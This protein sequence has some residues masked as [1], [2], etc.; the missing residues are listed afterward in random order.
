MMSTVETVNDVGKDSTVYEKQCKEIV[1]RLFILYQYVKSVPNFFGRKFEKITDILYEW[2]DNMGFRLPHILIA[3]RTQESLEQFVQFIN[4]VRAL[5]NSQ[6]YLDAKDKYQNTPL[7][8]AMKAT[9]FR[10]GVILLDV[11]AN[12][13]IKNQDGRTYLHILAFQIIMETDEVI[14]VEHFHMLIYALK[15]DP[16]SI[17]EKD[18]EGRTI[19]HYFAE[20]GQHVAL[21]IALEFGANSNIQDNYGNTPIFY[22]ASTTSDN[23]KECVF[24]SSVNGSADHR[25]TN[26]NGHNLLEYLIEI[27]NKEMFYFFH[28]LLSFRGMNMDDSALQAP[29]PVSLVDRLC[30]SRATEVDSDSIGTQ[31]SSLSLVTYA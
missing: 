18:N 13:G 6:Q 22:A 19:L 17:N 3:N 1:R 30:E 5:N 2:I 25:I 24:Q 20:A 16:S 23:H 11:G 29:L 15:K 8:W 4:I 10:A 12:V 14:R 9:N 7:H 28:E 27:N 26:N 31:F 21:K